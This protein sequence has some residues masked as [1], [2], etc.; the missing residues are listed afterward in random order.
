MTAPVLDLLAFG[1]HPDDVELAVGGTLALAARQG[2][3]VGIVHLTGGETGTRG[4][5][6]ERR[7]EAERAA[8]V[9]GAA[10][11]EILDCGDGGLR[12]GPAEEDR[13]IELLRRY[14]P[15]LVFGPPPRDRHPDHGRAHDLVEAA[16]F[17]AGVGKRRPDLG[18]PFRPAVT[19]QYMLHDPFRPDFVVD[20]TAVWEV[21]QRAVAAYRSQVYLEDEEREEPVTKI[22]SQ[23]FWHAVA[24]RARHYGN[25]VGATFGEPFTSR[26]PLAVAAPWDLVP[27]GIR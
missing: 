7:R 3:R 5:A 8:E 1:P 9:L 12:T 18:E 19:Y 27:H 4:T 21:R 14:R 6:A 22:S 15:D 13:L 10:V 20:V 11:M 24:G 2:K 23:D 17:Y 25:L 26:L 16:C